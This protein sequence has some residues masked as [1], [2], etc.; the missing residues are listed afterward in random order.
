MA[1]NAAFIVALVNA[2]ESDS[3]PFSV[4]PLADSI[5]LGISL[6]M[7]A[8]SE[9]GDTGESPGQCSLDSR[10]VGGGGGL[11]CVPSC[12]RCGRFGWGRHSDRYRLP[13]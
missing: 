6:F 13:G 12:L 3:C 9:A 2:T 8:V 7:L 4:R 11:G 5:A 10:V 1:F